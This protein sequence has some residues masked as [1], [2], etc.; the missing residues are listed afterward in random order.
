MKTMK[1]V[2]LSFGLGCWIC[3]GFGQTD[4]KVLM[5]EISLVYKG[6]CKDGLAHGEGEASGRDHFKGEFKKGLPHGKGVY[7]WTSGEVYEGSWRNGMR[8]GTGEYSFFF[9][10]KDSV[11]AGKW[12][13][14]EYIGVGDNTRP[15]T[16]EYRNNI[17]RVS[18]SRIGSSLNYVRLRF[19]RGSAEL[20][21]ED[22]FLYGSSG[23]ERLEHNFMGFDMVEFPFKGKATFTA[24]GS[25][26]GSIMNCEIRYT[27]NEP[28]TWVVNIYVN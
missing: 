3:L 26:H 24:P 19:I 25:W 13:K 1:R 27:I 9:Q 5:P 15:Y 20:T 23:T 4:C 14:D 6:E 8:H 17:G 18:F 16:I 28:G 12:V 11:L 2:M 21:V 10:G 7:E 22:L